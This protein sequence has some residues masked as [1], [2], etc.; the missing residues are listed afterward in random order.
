VGTF[1]RSQG[2]GDVGIAL[3]YDSGSAIPKST[4]AVDR[5]GGLSQ[6]DY[7]LLDLEIYLEA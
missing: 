7:C 4:G 1:Q 5:N 6:G 3:E 2:G